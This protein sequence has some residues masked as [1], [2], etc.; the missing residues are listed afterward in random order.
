MFKKLS[1]SR[2]VSSIVAIA[3][4]L[5]VGI[6]AVFCVMEMSGLADSITD[7]TLGKKLE[8][9]A[10]SAHYYLERY[11]G[12]VGYKD[13]QL[14][15]KEGNQIAGRYEMVDDIL[16]DLGDTA[17][18]FMK[19]GDDFRRVV[20]NVKKPDGSR[21]VGTLLGKESAAYGDIVKGKQYVGKANILGKP[22]LTSYMPL[23]GDNGEVTGILYIGIPREEAHLLTSKSVRNT[24]VMSGIIGLIIVV[25][26]V[27][28]SMIVLKKVLKEPISR[29]VETLK[30]ITESLDITKRIHIS[31]QDELGEMGRHY[32]MFIDKLHDTL[33]V[34]AGSSDTIAAGAEQLD[35]SSTKMTK[36]VERSIEQ[37]NSVA[38]A[39]EEMS[40]TTSEIARNCTTAAKNSEKASITA[41]GGEGV[42]VETV[43][44]M[45]RISEQVK[46]TA[47][48]IEGLDSQS[49]QIG[50]VVDLINDIADQTNLLALNAAIEAARAGEQGRGFAVVADEVRKLAEKTAEATK[51]IKK[52]VE[53]M[54]NEVRRSVETMQKT[55]QEVNVGAE[56]AKKSGIAFKD[57][58]DQINDVTS[59]INQIAAASEQQTSTTG[60]IADNIQHIFSAVQEMAEDIQGNAQSS[61]R[62]AHL[63]RDLQKLVGQF[64]L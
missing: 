32:N 5:S 14:V 57:V 54:Q 60:Q 23:K 9:D 41:T 16:N 21:A 31:S 43:R 56:G 50:Q 24:I 22:Y 1:I 13:G 6:V 53:T 11:Y 61:S 45:G 20:T 3:L 29:M 59:E 44:T 7:T 36:G 15:D 12:K 10:K 42:I 47:A 34:V 2:K 27:L 19:D 49:E 62:F 33:Q 64:K 37:A 38:T 26:F 51:G 28:L 63:S 48:V 30:E 25:V 40:A 55:V 35:T 4:L 58:L 17:T 46:V 8:G 18:L 39:A 52:N